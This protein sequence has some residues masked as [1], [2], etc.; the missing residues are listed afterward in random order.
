MSI[1]TVAEYYRRIDQNDMDWVVSL[2]SPDAVYERAEASYSGLSEIGRFFR[3][4][5]LIRGVHQIDTLVANSDADGDVVV[6]V[7][8]FDGTGRHGDPKSVGFADV[9][10][11]DTEGLVKKRQSYFALGSTYVRE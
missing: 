9:W 4:Q 7:G 11:F 5:R 2:F 3:E 10:R 1:S 6:A 8:R